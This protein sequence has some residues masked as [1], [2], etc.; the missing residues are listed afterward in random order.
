[1]AL[2]LFSEPLIKFLFKEG[3]QLWVFFGAAY[4]LLLAISVILHFHEK[5]WAAFHM[6]IILDILK[7]RRKNQT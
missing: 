3:S 6:E 4:L 7:E 1:M 5:A 2:F